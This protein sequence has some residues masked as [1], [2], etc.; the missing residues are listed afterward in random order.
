MK[1]V[2]FSTALSALLCAPVMAEMIDDPLRATLLVDRLEVQAAQD[3]RAVWDVSG[4][5]GKDLDKLA[6]YSEGESD[7]VG[8]ESRNELMYSRALTPFWDI[9]LGMEA[10]TS[11]SRTQGWGVVA[12]A[13][14]A[15]YFIDTRMRLKAGNKGV[16]L[17]FDFEYEMLITQRLIL[18]PRIEMEAYGK[19]I[20]EL[21][22]GSGFS[23]ME[24]GLRLRYEFVREFAPYA[25]VAYSGTFGNTRRYKAVDEISAVAG[26]RFWF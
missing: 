21:E 23:S 25:G 13:G 5:I 12:I 26:I 20:P 14:L 8:A 19:D 16:A 17:N 9:Q 4:Y 22:V 6:L 24:A 3:N 10:Q 7:G 11:G 1:K 18:T 2:W 15:P